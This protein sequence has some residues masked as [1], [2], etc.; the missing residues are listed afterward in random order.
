MNARPD[1]RAPY[2]DPARFADKV[3]CT[4]QRC[5]RARAI[6]ITRWHGVASEPGATLSSRL[7]VANQQAFA[8]HFDCCPGLRRALLHSSLL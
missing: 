2:D 4:L 1:P 7:G 3:V 5:S 8:G 6:A